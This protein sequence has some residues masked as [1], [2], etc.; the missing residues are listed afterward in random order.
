MSTTFWNN[1][2]FENPVQVHRLLELA[3]KNK[4]RVTP[5]AVR[6]Q[7]LSDVECRA[8]SSVA[9]SGTMSRAKWK[10]WRDS[11]C[12]S[13]PSGTGSSR[14]CSWPSALPTTSRL[15]LSTSLR[16]SCW[17]TR[18]SGTG[19]A[20]SSHSSIDRKVSRGAWLA[21]LIVKKCQRVPGQSLTRDQSDDPRVH[22]TRDFNPFVTA[23]GFG[24]IFEFLLVLQ[25]ICLLYLRG[26]GTFVVHYV[27]SKS[28]S[29]AHARTCPSLIVTSWL[30]ADI[31]SWS[32]VAWW[33]LESRCRFTFLKD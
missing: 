11:I 14:T 16:S 1:I 28:K 18:R 32:L 25:N 12:F 30:P 7:V 10:T 23:S 24:D 3:V 27:I 9:H 33:M 6:C 31:S 8:V 22:K 17:R 20:H 5:S 26:T 19:C 29:W 13:L 4:C 21:S 2:Y 15:K